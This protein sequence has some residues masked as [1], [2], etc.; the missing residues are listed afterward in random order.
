MNYSRILASLLSALLLCLP[1]VAEGPEAENTAGL[2]RAFVKGSR[3]ILAGHEDA[4]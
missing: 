2:V 3:E 4:R 1:V